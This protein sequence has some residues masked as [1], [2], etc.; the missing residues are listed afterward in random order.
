MVEITYR[1]GQSFAE[2]VQTF[3]EF[4]SKELDTHD[5]ENQPEYQTDQ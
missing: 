1:Y 3:E 2:L 5:G 4:A